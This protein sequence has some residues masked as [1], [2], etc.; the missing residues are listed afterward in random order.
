MMTK[1]EK[2]SAVS[3]ASK[4]KAT[5]K[6]KR[7]KASHRTRIRMDF[8]PKISRLCNQEE[9]DKSLTKYGF[10]LNLRIKVKFFSMVL[11]FLWLRLT[12]VY[13]CITKFW[14]RVKAADDRVHLQY[15]DILQDQPLSVVRSGLAYS[16]GF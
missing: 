15:S 8:D 5:I 3:G 9:V 6:E 7:K 4:G 2:S 1:G 14:H 12:M 16:L 11:T 13:I 10:R